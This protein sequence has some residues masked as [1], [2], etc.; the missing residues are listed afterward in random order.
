MYSRRWRTADRVRNV[1]LFGYC[2]LMSLLTWPVLA[3]QPV[4]T[5]LPVKALVTNF[6]YDNLPAAKKW[7]VDEMG[8]PVIYDD[9]WVVIVDVGKACKSRWSMHPEARSRL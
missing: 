2:V 8:F 7:Y 9:G 6:Y 4:R 1:M 3:S 5:P